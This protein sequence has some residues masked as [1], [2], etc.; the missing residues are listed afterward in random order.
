M[1]IPVAHENLRGRRWPYVTITIIGLNFIVFLFTILPMQKEMVRITQ[2]QLKVLAFNVLYP[3]ATMSADASHM[4]FYTKHHQPDEYAEFAEGVRNG[5][6]K[7]GYAEA[8][9]SLPPSD[10]QEAMDKLCTDYEAA[11]DG[12]I[13]W[14]FAF[15]PYHPKPWSYITAA[16]LHAGW[17][18]IIFNMWFLWLAG[19]ILED[20]W[21]RVVYPIFYLVCGVF[22]SV[23]HAMIFSG[24][25]MPVVGASGAIAGLMGAFL[26]RFPKTK[27]KMM[28]IFFWMRPFKFDVAAY[29]V[30]PLWLGIQL[31]W[32][33]SA[34]SEAGVAYWAHVGGFAFGMLGAVLLR[35]S[36]IEKKMDQAIESKVSLA[37]SPHIANAAEWLEQKRPDYAIVELEAELKEHPDSIEALELLLRAQ[38]KTNNNEAMKPTLATLVRNFVAAGDQQ[39]ALAYYDQYLNLGGEHLARGVWLQICRFYE[40]EKI[41]AR[42]A[43]EYEKFAE[44]NYLERSAVPAMVSSAQIYLNRLHRNDKA[45]QLFLAASA[46]PIPHLSS[47]GAIQEG[48]KACAKAVPRIGNY[49]STVTDE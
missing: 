23:C 17:L 38:E 28:W 41:W 33:I 49:A 24:S 3:D 36:G 22:A 35:S 32:G 40:A 14:D 16:F 37:V 45:E 5:L 42:A 27:I 19:T 7:S 34:P 1:L 11:R 25:M 43:D 48:L 2:A 4:V 13:M 15:H 6:D 29:I 8:A 47:E 9:A 46:S 20:A 10:A 18:H 21:G 30:L 26:A 12:T 44:V 31:A 39:Q